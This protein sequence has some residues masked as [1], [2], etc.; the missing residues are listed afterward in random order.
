MICHKSHI[1]IIRAHTSH[2]QLFRDLEHSEKIRILFSNQLTST[3]DAPQNLALTVGD[4][5]INASVD[6]Y[7]GASAYNWYL[8]AVL[9]TSTGAPNYQ[10]SGLTNEQAYDV[11][12]TATVGGIETKAT[13]IQQAT[14][15]DVVA[16]AA[17]TGLSAD[18]IA[19]TSITYSWDANAEADLEGYNAY[20]DG[21]KYNGSLI[22]PGSES[23]YVVSGLS[24]LT[25]YDFWVTAVDD[26]GNESP[27]SA[28]V[29]ETTVDAT[30]PSPPQ[31][32]TLDSEGDTQC[33]VSADASPSG[34]VDYY[35]AY[36]DDGGG[37]VKDNGANLTAGELSGYIF[38]VLVNG[39]TY[40]FW[41]T[42][43]DTSGNESVASTKVQGTPAASAA[44]E[45]NINSLSFDGV[46]DYATLDGFFVDMTS[47][48][49]SFWFKGTTGGAFR[50][51]GAIS[52]G[53]FAF[54]IIVNPSERIIVRLVDDDG[55]ALQANYPA[56]SEITDGN[57]H[58]LG[59]TKTGNTF[60]LFIDGVVVP[61][62]SYADSGTPDN[63][64][65]FGVPLA[66]GARNNNGTI[67]N[68]YNGQIDEI[69]FY[70]S[71]LTRAQIVENANKILTGS[72]TDLV[73]YWNSEDRDPTQ[74]TDLTA[75][76]NHGTIN[77][78]TYAYEAADFDYSLQMD[79]AA[80]Y[81]DLGVGNL[82]GSNAPAVTFECWVYWVETNNNNPILIT[83][84][85]GF[86]IW[87]QI[88]EDTNSFRFAVRNSSGTRVIL[89]GGS[90]T[91]QEWTHVAGTYDGATMKIIVNGVE[92]VSTAH[93]GT[94]DDSAYRGV[95]GADPNF[96][97]T[98]EGFIDKVRIWS[99]GRTNVEIQQ[100]MNRE[101]VGDESGLVG[102]YKF[103]DLSDL[104]VAVDS[105]P[106]G[107]DGTISGA[108]YS[109][110]IVSYWQG[111][112]FDGA[113][114]YVDAGEDA[115]LDISGAITIEAWVYANSFAGGREVVLGNGRCYD[116]TGNTRTASF[117]L[118]CVNDIPRMQIWESNT[119]R[120]TINSGVTLATGKWYHLA[121][122]WDG[123][124]NADNM[125]FYID[126]VEV[127]TSSQST[128]QS[129]FDTTE[130]VVIGHDLVRLTEDSN[131][132]MA[133]DGY[134]DE[135]RL[136]NVG[137]TQ[138][139]IQDNM[140]LALEG[141]EA[142]LV[143]YWPM[144]EAVGSSVYDRTSN[145]N[146]GAISGAV[147]AE[148]VGVKP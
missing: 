71:A 82:L 16:P 5:V 27:A 87:L 98:L 80:D 128:V 4:N 18:I 12:A 68:F 103:D 121:A 139:E 85:S 83:V 66:I 92:A 97:N 45:N 137:R 56:L 133:W 143:G 34:D 129:L 126:G 35:N 146:N 107:N 115:S 105:S 50:Y 78:A 7:S 96:N 123:T 94:L 101:L 118:G 112:D 30:A 148:S 144:D 23:N 59:L 25:E 111:L 113:N 21:V 20:L 41:F 147:F 73:G 31:N 89:D 70:S 124:N 138:Q 136:W 32:V 93:S 91:P 22:S 62:D 39:T 131:Q 61:R 109:T 132:R 140:N 60:T 11:F 134:L 58:H 53:N 135:V 108:K 40:D 88:R 44:T 102:L 67:D 90:I 106:N 47:F 127:A 72:E 141:N 125:K 54:Q 75:N 119:V 77:G 38:D 33:T 17:P 55:V 46:D 48:S 9:I 120:E 19:G 116:S 15:T 81:V 117:F 49:T 28:T 2:L 8:D 63:F 110:D 43:V 104:G 42:A 13:P 26:D 100:N 84:S 86:D 57:W 14:P 29:T 52:S 76:A 95:I 51:M 3:P 142:G 6:A 69:Q 10:F 1:K 37:A 64:S 130:P 36:R 114:D 24:E 99:V 122:V 145:G 79:G 65:S 74:L